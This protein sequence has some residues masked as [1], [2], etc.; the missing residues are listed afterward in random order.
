MNPTLKVKQLHP[1][2]VIPTYARFGDA[3]LDLT[4]TEVSIGPLCV[5]KFGIAVEIPDGYEAT[6]RP[7]SSLSKAGWHVALGTIDSGYRGELMCIL[8]RLAGYASGPVAGDRVAQLVV[9]PVACCQVE[10]VDELSKTARGEGGFG[11][12]GK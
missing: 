3:G 1:K 10:I 9:T 7:R 12:T 4:A 11:H 6:I 2:A 8:V 5:C